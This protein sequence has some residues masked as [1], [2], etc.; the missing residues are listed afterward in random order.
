MVHYV[1]SP[2]FMLISLLIVGLTF[3]YAGF[4]TL[5][6]TRKL[7]LFIELEHPTE[8]QRKEFLGYQATL[9]GVPTKAIY[10]AILIALITGGIQLL[11][12]HQ[13]T[14]Q[15]PIIW[16]IGISML[17]LVHAITFAKYRA[18]K[19]LESYLSPRSHGIKHK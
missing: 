8:S 11:V 5:I 19:R 14:M 10:I 16:F 4:M 1:M 3:I 9:L 15:A 12:T 18:V 2:N 13:A 7:Y 17:A 6:I